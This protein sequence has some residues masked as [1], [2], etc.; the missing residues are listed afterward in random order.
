MTQATE[1]RIVLNPDELSLPDR[2]K[3]IIG[4]VVPRPIAW[5]STRSKAGKLNLAPFSYFNAVCTNPPTI[6]F[7]PAVRGSD[8][9]KKDTLVNVEETGEFVVNI[10]TDDVVEKMNQTAAE[11]DYGVSEFEK[12]GL[13]PAASEIVKPPRVQESPINMECTLQQII[14]VGDGS[15]GSGFIVLGTIVRFHVRPDIYDNGKIITEKL[16]PV[17]RLAGTNY[18]HVREIFSLA[19]PEAD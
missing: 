10:V 15:R 2:Y 1:N 4:S 17:G 16:K 5:V 18:C 14:P 19:R 6:L 11:Y 9:V 3:L 13:T 8:G 12:T 7:C